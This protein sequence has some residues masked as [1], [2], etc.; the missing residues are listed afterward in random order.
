M[1]FEFSHPAL[2]SI[3]LILLF[4]FEECIIDETDTKHLFISVIV[5][6]NDRNIR[7]KLLF[8]LSSNICNSDTLVQQLSTIKNDTEKP[9]RLSFSIRI[10]FWNDEVGFDHV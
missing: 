5:A 9:L 10:I 8:D 4:A 1:L 2:I 6:K 3:I 7:G